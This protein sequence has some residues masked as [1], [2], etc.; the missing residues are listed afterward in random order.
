M[1]EQTPAIFCP[2]CHASVAVDQPGNE[3][4][5]AN[6]QW[7][8]QAW[9]FEPLEAPLDHPTDALPEDAVCAH[10]PNKKAEA[11]CAGTGDYICSLCAVT[12]NGQTFAAM[13][14]SQPDAEQHLPGQVE[15]TLPRPERRIRWLLLLSILPCYQVLLGPVFLVWAAV[16]WVRLVRLRRAQPLYRR[17][18]GPGTAIAA[19]LGILLITGLWVFFAAGVALWF[20]EAA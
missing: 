20:A 10:H 3:V 16:E 2:Q 17:V 18:V 4:T 9:A 11:I 6:C 5:C 13:Y 8:G 19:L 7:Q 14:L 1:V 12:V 15:R